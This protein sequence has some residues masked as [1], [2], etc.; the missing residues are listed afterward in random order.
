MTE[1]QFFDAMRSYPIGVAIPPSD[2]DDAL[3]T[4]DPWRPVWRKFINHPEW[5]V[6]T[7]VRTNAED[8]WKPVANTQQALELRDKFGFEISYTAYRRR[9]TLWRRSEV[10]RYK[11]LMGV[12]RLVNPVFDWFEEMAKVP[13]IRH[14]VLVAAILFKLAAK[15]KTLVSM[16]VA[17]AAYTWVFGLP[18][19]LGLI[20]ML[21]VHEM[22]H[23]YVIRRYGMKATAP[24]FIPFVGA[25]INMEETPENAWDEAMIGFGGPLVGGLASLGVMMLSQYCHSPILQAIAYIGFVLNL[26]NMLPIRP[27]DGGRI[28]QAVS[29]WFHA[30]GCVVGVVLTFVVASPL[31][32]LMSVIGI[33]EIAPL[34]RM[35]RQKNVPLLSK[36]AVGV[37]YLVT[38]AVLVYGAEA[39]FLTNQAME[40]LKRQ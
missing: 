20:A 23:V 16:L 18:F 31:L 37:A 4:C 36:L 2:I 33:T 19:A 35:G 8:P 1:G 14:V 34:F 26:F 15:G 12:G 13:G 25:F 40:I 39:T 5:D 17:I 24:M 32:G 38:I 7:V 28:I 22:G 11:V 3:R 9:V 27:M 6:R 30:F 10:W 21:F 29:P